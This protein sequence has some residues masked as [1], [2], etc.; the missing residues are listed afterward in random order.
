MDSTARTGRGLAEPA[1][2]TEY[3][4]PAASTGHRECQSD[5]AHRFA[6][7]WYR[8]ALLLHLAGN[9][10]RGVGHGLH[11]N[12]E[13]EERSAKLRWEGAC[14]RW[15]DHRRCVFCSRIALLDL[16]NFYHR[17]RGLWAN[18]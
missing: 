3:T 17:F 7:L 5:A 4:V 10:H 8:V 18:A 9:R 6:G 11:G 14:D 2:R 15:N 16:H 12:E 13:R 1:D